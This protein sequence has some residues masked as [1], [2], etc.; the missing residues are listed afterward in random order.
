MNYKI[1]MSITNM[2]PYQD[3]LIT[4]DLLIRLP[5]E[6]PICGPKHVATIK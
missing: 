3:S 1:M 6:G 4:G 5:D 2:D